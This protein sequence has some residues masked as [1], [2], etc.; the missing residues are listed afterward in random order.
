MILQKNGIVQSTL[1]NDHDILHGVTTKQL[2]NMSYDRDQA[3][4]GRQAEKNLKIFLKQLGIGLEQ[5]NLLILPVNHTSN[6]AMIKKPRKSGRMV[7][8]N[9]SNFVIKLHEFDEEEGFDA[10]IC[11]DQ[12]AFLAILPADCAPVMLYDKKT[13]TFALIHAG[14][15]GIIAGIIMKTI[16]CLKNWCQTQPKNILCYIGPTICPDCYKPESKSFDLVAEITWQLINSGVMENNIKPS[17]F[18]TYH[19]Q[20]L[21]YSNARS[22]ANENEGRQIAIIGKK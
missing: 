2:G 15:S 17:Q 21:F 4:Q 8:R 20:H 22:K 5:Q 9:K 10:C 16:F 13:G 12:N 19:D 1:F 11:Q 18:C 6:V 3:T 7:I 14:K